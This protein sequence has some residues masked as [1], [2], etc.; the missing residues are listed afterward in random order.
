MDSEAFDTSVLRGSRWS[1]SDEHKTLRMQR[2]VVESGDFRD[3][4]IN[5]ARGH[6]LEAGN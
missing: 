5:T 2:R 6:A 1:T 3:V 4:Y